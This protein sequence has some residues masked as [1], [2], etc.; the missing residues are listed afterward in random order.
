M[1]I[2]NINYYKSL[3]NQVSFG[4]TLAMLL[5]YYNEDYPETFMNIFNT[6]FESKEY[7]DWLTQRG[8]LINDPCPMVMRC[9][10]YIIETY[11]K[12]SC[13][14]TKSPIEKIMH[15]FIKR[16]IPTII[17]NKYIPL[18]L[19]GY[20]DNFIIVNDPM[21]NLNTNYLEKFG[22]N[23][24]YKLSDIDKTPYFLRLN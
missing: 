16:R 19:K 20:T 2:K 5:S 4:S 24:L 9:M 1:I 12:H 14:I 17:F 23:L 11:T 6:T 21:G 15:S 10:E 18:L 8:L 7:Y 13:I 3:D 22:E